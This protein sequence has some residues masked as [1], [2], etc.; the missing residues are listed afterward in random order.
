MN[1]AQRLLKLVESLDSGLDGWKN[2]AT[3]QTLKGMKIENM[4]KKYLSCE[5][6]VNSALDCY[7]ISLGANNYPNNSF[8]EY[9]ELPY[10]CTESDIMEI[11]KEV[12]DNEEYQSYYCDYAYD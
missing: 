5:V 10:D 4:L 8:E 2:P 3:R 11:I 12:E 7:T 1:K 9:Y 6:T